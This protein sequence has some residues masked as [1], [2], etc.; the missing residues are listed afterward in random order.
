MKKI[1]IIG[2]DGNIDVKTDIPLM[3]LGEVIPN[4]EEGCEYRFVM[5][6]KVSGDE[7]WVSRHSLVKTM[8]E[9]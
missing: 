3:I 9:H 1:K 7:A 8:E 2:D 5:N 4:L 6:F